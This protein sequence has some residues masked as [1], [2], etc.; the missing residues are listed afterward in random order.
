MPQANSLLTSI[1]PDFSIVAPDYVVMADTFAGERHIKDATTIYL[2]LTAGMVLDGATQSLT[3]P[4][5]LRYVNYLARAKFPDYVQDA[6]STLVGVLNRE[7]ARIQLPAAMEP[8]RE[9][10]TRRGESLLMLLRRI[11]LNQLLYGRLALL[12][13]AVQGR[14]TPILLD[15]PARLLVNW[16]DEP[17]DT[18]S[19]NEL[20]MAILD[21]TRPEIGTDG[22]TWTTV[23][24]GR[25][26]VLTDDSDPSVPTPEMIDGAERVASLAR[27]Y[28]TWT[29]VEGRKSAVVEPSLAGRTLPFIPLTVVGATDLALSPGIIP[30]LGLARLCL[31]IYRGEADYRQSLH[32]QG[33]DTLVI[34]GEEGSPDDDE[35]SDS[36]DEVRVGVGSVIRVPLQGDAKFI[37]VS[38]LALQEQ[39]T[40]LSEERR[41]AQGKGAQLL[42]PPG[43]QAESGDALRIRI[44]AATATLQSIAL[45]GAAGLQTALRQ[46]ATWM[47]AD[48]EAVIVT[49]NLNF[50]EVRVEPRSVGDAMDAK[51]KGAPLS[52]RSIH[53]Y[54][55][56]NGLTEM[57]FEDELAEI[58]GEEPLVEPPAPANPPAGS[59][60]P[61][62]EEDP[63]ADAE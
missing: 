17:F 8:M 26:L 3:S 49:P 18:L 30:L 33:Q 48:P 50:A 13:D 31:S 2:P 7:P 32:H 35:E 42:H 14:N 5:W 54:A 34:I 40:A 61:S 6:A 44:A 39:R 37:G 46:C 25:A 15:Y 53:S 43:S 19:P 11:H 38:S 22:L 47:G 56:K 21:E 45:T 10:A 20:R 62:P 57:T 9:S 36:E 55:E 16:S 63:P 59:D 28:R 60:I 51:A 1:H 58:E 52:L 27:T 24:R 29:E 4:G 23:I 12:G 41:E